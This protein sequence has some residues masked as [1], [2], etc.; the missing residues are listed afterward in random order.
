V[1][2][3]VL[4][5][6][7]DAR[8]TDFY[9]N[10]L[11]TSTDSELLFTAAEYVSASFDPALEYRCRRLLW[12][13]HLGRVRAI[14]SLLRSSKLL[15]NSERIRIGILRPSEDTQLPGF[16]EAREAWLR[17][18]KGPFRVDTQ[19]CLER[20]GL[21]TLDDL[22]TAWNSLAEE[23]REWLVDWVLRSEVNAHSKPRL[24][25]IDRAAT[26]IRRRSQ[27]FSGCARQYDGKK[28]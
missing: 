26:R 21:E 19:I 8:V 27:L 10:I 22:L 7:R 24:N 6:F 11:A 25:L 13:E 3:I 15:D 14:A 23:N 17:E 2:V 9:T 1:H 16:D 12:D 4:T 28:Q 18:L 20:Q 5:A